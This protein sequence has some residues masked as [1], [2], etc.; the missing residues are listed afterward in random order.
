MALINFHS[1]SRR[2][3]NLSLAGQGLTVLTADARG[4]CDYFFSRFT[5]LFYVSISLEDG[6]I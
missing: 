4:L 1:V 6:S 2:P 3:T 5:C